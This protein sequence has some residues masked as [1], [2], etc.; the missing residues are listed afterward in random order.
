MQYARSLFLITALF[1]LK[2]LSGQ[3]ISYLEQVGGAGFEEARD[4]VVGAD[5]TLAMA[6]ST[7]S[8]G[9]NPSDL[10]RNAYVVKTQPDGTVIWTLAVGGIYL[11]E[12]MGIALVSDGGYMAVGTSWSATQNDMLV[13][14]VSPN[15]ALVW[16]KTFGVINDVE[17]ANDIVAMG[18]DHFAVVGVTQPAGSADANMLTLILDADGNTL[19][20]TKIGSIHTDVA[21]GA[22]LALDGGLF[23][24]GSTSPQYEDMVLAK[25]DA[26]GTFDWAEKYDLEFNNGGS[27]IAVAADGSAYISGWHGLEN[28][29][30]GNV[31]HVDSAGAVIWSR[32]YQI[33]PSIPVY[34]PH[35]LIN[36]SGNVLATGVV[37]SNSSGDEHLA[38]LLDPDGGILAKVGRVWVS[39]GFRGW[40]SVQNADGSY[41]MSGNMRWGLGSRDVLLIGTNAENFGLGGPCYAADLTPFSYTGVQSFHGPVFEALTH[42]AMT[43]QPTGWLATNGGIADLLCDNVGHAEIISVG[44]DLS[45]APQPATTELFVTF[46]SMSQ[47]AELD[48]F[49]MRGMSVLHQTFSDQD[50]ILLDVSQIA[51]G[52]YVC[53][54]TTR[55]GERGSTRVV[56]Q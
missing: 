32:D 53:R 7:G 1:L 33:D 52:I 46:S 20:T 3:G 17:W 8:Y 15:G 23:I 14:R 49:D 48:L 6:G 56:L 21:Y 51:R 4:I 43:G 39:G 26:N 18:N 47:T 9:P 30:K 16:A 25:L 13:I 22:A 2:Q 35:I 45:V 41:S 38:L 44:F 10:N 24:V 34:L 42:P 29:T 55:N 37:T 11:D 5:G 50:R 40:A 54:I 31:T 27:S 12:L 28:Y 36:D 19:Q